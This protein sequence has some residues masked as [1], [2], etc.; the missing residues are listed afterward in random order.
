MKKTDIAMIILI[1]SVSMLIAYFAISAI[2]GLQSVNKPVSVKT[3]SPISSDIGQPD[4]SV[5]HDGAINPTI[6]VT[7][8]GNNDSSSE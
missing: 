4:G 7:I 5:F 2:P 8:G 1:A 6:P 3:A